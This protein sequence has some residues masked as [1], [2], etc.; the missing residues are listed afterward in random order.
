M[1]SSVGTLN[2]RCSSLRI[3]KEEETLDLEYVLKGAKERRDRV[4]LCMYSRAHLSAHVCVDLTLNKYTE[5]FEKNLQGRLQSRSKSGP[6]A[7][8]IWGKKQIAL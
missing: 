6:R 4:K 1:H 2:L 3:K 5:A 8:D 7:A